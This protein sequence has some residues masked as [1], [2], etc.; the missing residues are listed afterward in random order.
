MKRL[1]PEEIVEYFKDEFGE[2]IDDVKIEK[3]A[4]GPGKKEFS[5]IWLKIDRDLIKKA[6]NHLCGIQFPH[7]S[8]MTG[9]DEDD[10]LKVNYHFTL[11]Y[12]ERLKEISVNISADLPKSDPTIESI[13]DIIPGA[14]IT[15]RDVQDML[16]VTV[17]NIPDKRRIFLPKGFPDGVHPWRK[18]EKGP[19]DLVRDMYD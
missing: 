15:E 9:S 13:C 18:D 14:L 1:S 12:G 6:V 3:R 5:N 19:Q 7:L 8:V 4:V 10:H 11:Y 17:K 16:G 2:K